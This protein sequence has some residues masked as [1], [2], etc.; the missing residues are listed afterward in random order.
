[1][2]RPSPR[3]RFIALAGALLLTIGAAAPTSAAPQTRSIDL[4]YEG[5]ATPAYS[6]DINGVCDSCIPDTFRVFLGAG[7]WAYGAT[8]TG[9]VDSLRWQATTSTALRYDDA[10]LRQGQTLGMSD[11]LTPS[12]G[13]IVATGSVQGSVGL[14]NDPAGGTNFGPSGA[15]DDVDKAATWTITGCA[16]PLPGDSPRTCVSNTQ[17]IELGSKTVAGGVLGSLKIVLSVKLR[18]VVQVASDGI[19]VARGLSVVGGSGSLDRTLTFLGSTP[20]TL[21]DPVALSC[22]LPSGND[23]VYAFDAQT[24]EPTA[25]VAGRGE[26]HAA[27]VISFPLD[28][29]VEVFGG[30][31]QTVSAATHEFDISLAGS[32]GSATLGSLAKNNVPPVVD[33]GGGTS[34]EYSG[35]QGAP[36]AFD[37]SASSSV[38]GFPTL[39]W[40]FSDGGVAFGPKPKHTFEGSGEYSGLLTATD[41]TGLTS[42]QTFNVTVFNL[43]PIVNAGFDTTAAWGRLVA[44]NGQATDPGKDDQ[45][46]LTYQWRFGDGS[47]SAT[48]GPSVLHSYTTPGTY[49][50]TFTACDRVGTCQSDTRDV[51]VR[52]R[53]VSVGNLGDTA[54]IFDTA[55]QLRASLVDEFG[56][57]V[58]GRT[59]G[60]SVGGAAVGSAVTNSAGLG[61]VAWTPN[62]A[63]GTYLTT[64]SFEGDSLYSAADGSSTVAIG[65]KAS[66]TTYTG[67]LTGGPNKTIT[68]SAKLVD[69]TGT[70]LGGRTISFK[71]GS[72]TT[73]A[74][75]SAGGVASAQLKLTQK[76]G[77][78]PLTATWSP[79]GADAARYLGSAAS[80]T[81]KLQAR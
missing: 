32:G 50:A 73:S 18:L 66:A 43:A 55:S 4:A 30:T 51:I 49:T 54:A 8:T 5:D 74:V 6:F 81:F 19:I 28:V 42:V 70:A 24:Y 33:S 36:I 44:F 68:L 71:L 79:S 65:H 25:T 9:R 22:T 27:A 12:G 46:T 75:T 37:G 45:A 13:T 59:I 76:N 60:F 1:M 10:L 40:D 72:Q 64:A 47:P 41:A 2:P 17:D 56:Q 53:N 35:D 38:C 23:V 39:R 21:A 52:A 58:N 3:Q 63:A 34:H 57:Q 7:S 15:S 20:S 11:V 77:T 16:M 48:S 80:A 62:L 26:L 78:Y 69:A 67:T 31:I 29:E 61:A 14:L